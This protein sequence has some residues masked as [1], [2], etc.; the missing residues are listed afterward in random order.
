[1]RNDPPEDYDV[2]EEGEDFDL[3]DDNELDMTDRLLNKS[4]RS[5]LK[6][7]MGRNPK[8]QNKRSIFKETISTKVKKQEKFAINIDNVNGQQWNKN[9]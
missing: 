3:D 8:L 2:H 7:K 6:R 4:P 9:Q 5:K 1:M